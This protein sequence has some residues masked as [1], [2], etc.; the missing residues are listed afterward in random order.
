VA[1]GDIGVKIELQ[2]QFQAEKMIYSVSKNGARSLARSRLALTDQGTL[3][4]EVS[5]YG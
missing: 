1:A 3:K 2:F 4:V 5:L